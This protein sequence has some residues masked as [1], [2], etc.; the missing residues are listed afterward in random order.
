MNDQVPQVPASIERVEA[1]PV[2][3]VDP[4]PQQPSAVK[5]ASRQSRRASA[6]PAAAPVTAV[7]PPVTAAH[8]YGLRGGKR[9]DYFA[10]VH[11]RLVSMQRASI[12]AALKADDGSAAKEA[13][14][15]ELTS[16][17]L[18]HKA[19]APVH[20]SDITSEHLAQVVRSHCFVVNKENPDGSFNKKKARLVM[21]GDTQPEDT[22]GDTTSPTVNPITLMTLFSLMASEDMEAT[23]FDVPSAFL[24]PDMDGDEIIYTVIDKALTKE[25]V[26]LIPAL[27]VYVT[28]KGTMYFK[29]KK[30]IYGLKQASRKF[31]LHMVTFFTSLG[32]EAAKSDPCLFTK[33]IGIAGKKVMCVMH[34][35]DIFATTP[36][37]QIIE[38]LAHELKIAMG[39]EHKP[40]QQLSFIGMTVT[41]D[42]AQRT[43]KVNMV[44]YTASIIEK[45]GKDASEANTPAT[46]DLFD[47]PTKSTPLT[48]AEIGT[49]ASL[50]MSLMFLARFTRPDIL[51][52]VSFLAVRMQK[53]TARD[54]MHVMRIVRYLKGTPEVGLNFSHAEGAPAMRFYVDASHAVHEDG[55]GQGAFVITLGTAP[56]FAKTWK[57]KHVTLSST[58][59]ELSGL[60]EAATYVLWGR[61]LMKELGY[62]TN[63][64]T[65]VFE[66]NRSAIM[67][68]NGGKGTF[69]R[70]KHLLVRDAF[71]TEHVVNGSLR[72]QYCPTKDMVADM[73]TKPLDRATLQHLMGLA[74]VY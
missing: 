41:R 60:S 70:S 8:Q 57:L 54:M 30:Y 11:A 6:T 31:Y 74:H 58:E 37:S 34:V 26:E 71:V 29:L 35:D 21:G 20:K 66:D 62:E 46:P 67:M 42:R 24:V 19:L 32:F 52:A 7:E 2:E 10:M 4:L 22:Y 43:A 47:R 25:V 44:G 16:M 15:K 64:P 53:P 63:D 59:A 50:L 9:P 39:V 13:I 56:V 27:A 40:S 12:T 48:A 36:S 72:L 17:L 61:L 51:L 28:N 33:D 68:T 38:W 18:V 65:V 73:L 45:Y 5:P 49:F 69:K 14:H 55:K 1:V 23:T 3:R